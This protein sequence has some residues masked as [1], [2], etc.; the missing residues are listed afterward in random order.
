ML[1]RTSTICPNNS[2]SSINST[3][4]TLIPTPRLPNALISLGISK[5]CGETQHL[6]LVR[7]AQCLT[8][9]QGTQPPM[10]PRHRSTITTLLTMML[11]T[12]SINILATTTHTSTGER[13]AATAV[14]KP[15]LNLK[16]SLLRTRAILSSLSGKMRKAI[17]VATGSRTTRRKTNSLLLATTSRSIKFR[18]MDTVFLDRLKKYTKARNL[19]S[20][21]L[22]FIYIR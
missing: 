21:I 6:T 11:S 16:L 17:S 7:L 19:A 14:I 12:R 4:L 10:S 13:T 20:I 15:R 9:S 18:I 8:M 1:V 5:N 2:R 3:I 22:I